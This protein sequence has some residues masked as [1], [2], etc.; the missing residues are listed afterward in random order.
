MRAN[1][2]Q[3][4]HPIGSLLFSLHLNY[5]LLS[6]A[7]SHFLSSSPSKA[8]PLDIYLYEAEYSVL[9][10]IFD[11]VIPHIGR[12]RTL[13]ISSC[14]FPDLLRR[15]SDLA[16]IPRLEYFKVTASYKAEEVPN[17]IRC[18]APRLHTL[19]VVP[20]SLPLEA[21]VLTSV[22]RLEFT[23]VVE[24]FE[25]SPSQWQAILCSFPQLEFIHVDGVPDMKAKHMPFPP[26]RASIPNLQKISLV[27][28][29]A[30]TIGALLSSICVDDN[31]FPHIEIRGVRAAGGNGGMRELF[32]ASSEARSLLGLIR[33]TRKIS[34]L[35]RYRGSYMEISAGGEVDD[36]SLYLRASDGPEIP[37]GEVFKALLSPSGLP[38]LET[39]RIEGA[40][41]FEGGTVVRSLSLLPS[42]KSF[43]L[44]AP[45]QNPQYGEHHDNLGDICNAMTLP[46]AGKD[47]GQ[48]SWL[49][50]QLKEL[51]IATLDGFEGIP[52]MIEARYGTC[53]TSPQGKVPAA[54]KF[55]QL[56]TPPN[57]APS[58]KRPIKSSD[59]ARLNKV[60]EGTC[61]LLE[62][63]L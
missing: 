31:V 17:F 61:I 7:D 51:K 10:N 23:P 13:Q 40:P 25:L 62:I 32:P 55:L 30:S 34:S 41:L 43:E 6:I 27:M 48:A 54:L 37:I 59:E 22:R 53:T 16:S 42:L 44:V 58:F 26:F 63:S 18:G 56:R 24:G 29:P 3:P 52:P 8:A 11:L 12:W 1:D 15:I 60:L 33:S 9:E 2:S 50:P 4:S 49:L 35:C 28:L 21:P 19:S 46:C 45:N 20:F 57:M 5:G 47:G 39:L 36:V 38:M 14:K